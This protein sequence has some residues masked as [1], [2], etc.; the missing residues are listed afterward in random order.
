MSTESVYQCNSS[1]GDG[2]I[3]GPAE[4]LGMHHCAVPTTAQLTA[5]VFNIKFVSIPNSVNTMV[6]NFLMFS[7]FSNN[8]SIGSHMPARQTMIRMSCHLHFATRL[9]FSPCLLHYA[10]R[11]PSIDPTKNTRNRS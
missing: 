1:D 9:G 4:S 2:S 7:I 11:D 10:S 3:S 5:K 8:T 6:V